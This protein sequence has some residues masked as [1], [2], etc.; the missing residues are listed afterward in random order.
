MG[1]GG[2]G[3]RKY[4]LSESTMVFTKIAAGH[5]LSKCPKEED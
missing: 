2:G 5:F 3:V 1:G 4:V